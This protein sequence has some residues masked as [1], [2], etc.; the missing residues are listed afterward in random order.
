MERWR[1]AGVRTR[2]KV[3]ADESRNLGGNVL[4][5]FMEPVLLGDRLMCSRQIRGE[6][7]I[8]ENPILQKNARACFRLKKPEEKYEDLSTSSDRASGM[9]DRLRET[10]GSRFR[11]E[12]AKSSAGHCPRPLHVTLYVHLR[13]IRKVRHRGAVSPPR[14]SA[15]SLRLLEKFSGDEQATKEA[16]RAASA[17]VHPVHC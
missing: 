4:K 2:G 7:K 3:F 11:G 5:Y 16:T 17:R 12:V 9:L 8:D 13:K 10:A 14:S 6:R 1:D 15:L